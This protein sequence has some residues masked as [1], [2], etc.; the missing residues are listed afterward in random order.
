[1]AK[2]KTGV[3]SVRLDTRIIARLDYLSEKHRRK[4]NWL[5]EQILGEKVGIDIHNCK[6]EDLGTEEQ[7]PADPAPENGGGELEI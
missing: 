1:M 3:L 2:R 6:E 7:Q 4:R 5:I